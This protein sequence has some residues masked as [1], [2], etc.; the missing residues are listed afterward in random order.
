MQ[1]VTSGAEIVAALEAG[2]YVKRFDPCA[3]E[4]WVAL[5]MWPREGERSVR[6]TSS[7]HTRRAIAD[8]LKDAIE[9]P[10]EWYI[11]ESGDEPKGDVE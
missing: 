3:A 8:C 11:A 2:K 4:R 9:H 1:Q 6:I 10:L 7:F 5:Y